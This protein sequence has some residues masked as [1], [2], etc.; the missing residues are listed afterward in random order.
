MELISFLISRDADGVTS[1][2][3]ALPVTH[4]N[5]SNSTSFKAATEEEA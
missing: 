4:R 5:T 3:T 1:D 2:N